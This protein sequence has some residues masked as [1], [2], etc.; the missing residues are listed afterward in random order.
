M[1]VLNTCRLAS[2]DELWRAEFSLAFQK[3]IEL[4]WSGKLQQRAV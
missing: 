1:F 2:D 4:G 3:L